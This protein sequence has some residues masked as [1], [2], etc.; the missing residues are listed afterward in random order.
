M[1]WKLF[2]L[3]PW[4]D[5]RASFV[6]RAPKNGTLLDL[7][8][9]DG[10]TLRHMSELRPDLRLYAADKFGKPEAYP[11][12]CEFRRLDFVTEQLPWPNQ[13][14][15]AITC[16]HV[17]EHLEKLDLIFQEVARVL[18]PGGRVYFETPHPKTLDLPSAKGEYTWNFYD[19][20]THVRVV[21]GP[22][23]HDRARA[24]G[25]N[26]ESTG[27]SRNLLFAAAYPFSFLLRGAKQRFTTRGHWLGWTT[28]LVAARPD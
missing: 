11:K 21:S 2:R 27:I 24:V 15:D 22:E 9:S 8:S 13:T 16:M 28:Y 17:V 23:L 7:G 1:N 10:E 19:D 18:K 3:W 6:A 26:V 14:F 5:T 25:M 20:P 4:V 12:G